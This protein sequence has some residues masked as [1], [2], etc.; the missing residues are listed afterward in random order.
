M[1]KQYI[2]EVWC[3]M[4]MFVSSGDQPG[5]SVLN[6]LQATDLVIRGRKFLG[7]WW[8][9]ALHESKREVIN[10][11]TNNSVAHS[12]RYQTILPTV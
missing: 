7:R 2:T 11:C 3:N 10:A 12:V 8:S 1:S 5:S 9:R 4:L 6:Q